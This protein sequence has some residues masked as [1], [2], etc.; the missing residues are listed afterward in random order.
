M[1]SSMDKSLYQAP[2]GLLEDD[3]NAEITD[4]EIILDGEDPEDIED[5][6]DPEFDDNLVDHMDERDVSSLG[7]EL[8]EHFDN[9]CT[10][11]K[12]WAET[13]VKGLKLLGLK[14]EERTEPWGGACGAYHPI[15]AEAVV[16]FQA[17]SIMEQFPASGPVKTKIV[18]K[19]TKEN[20]AAAARVMEDMNFQLTE[21]MVEYRPEHEKLLWSLPLAGSAFKKV[22][23]DPTM[24]RQVALFVPAED[25][26]VPYGASSLETSERVTHVMRKTKNELKKMQA[27]GFYCDVE[28]GEPTNTVDDIEKQKAEEQGFSTTND[29]RFKVL[30]MH[31]DLDLIGFEDDDGIALPYI[32]TI[33]QGT[34]T[35]LS[36]RRNWYE[37]DVLRLKR[38]HFV[39]YTYVP[40][41]GF[42]GLGL[43]HLVGG[44]AQSATSILRQLV[45][46][47]TLSNLPG[48]FKTKG[49]RVKGDDT[50]V[51]PGEFRDV[52]VAS[53][54]LKDNI[55]PLPYK[56]PSQTLYLLMQN[57]VEEGRRFASAGDL[58]ISDMSANT[59]VGTT[60]A[61]LER[62]L[63]T[64]SAVQAR[65]HFAMK[66]EFKL[67]A[68][69]TRD[70]AADSEYGYEVDGGD[71]QAQ[72]KQ[73]DYDMCEV[74]PVSDPNASTMSQKIVQHQ[75]AMQ[76]ANSAPQLYDLAL[77]HRQG[78]EILGMKNVNKLVPMADDQ[79]PKDPVSENMA[80]LTMKPV[81]AFQYQDHEAH[82]A[83]H[84][85]MAQDP[86]IAAMVG[87]N[88]QAQIIIANGAAHL[89]EH[90]AM[91]YKAAIEKQLGVPLPLVDEDNPMSPEIE[92]QVSKLAAQAA[93]QLLQAN[94]AEAAQQ[95]AQQ[96]AQDPVIQMQQQELKI[97]EREVGVKEMAVKIDAA[98]RADK[99][100]LEEARL[101]QE[102]RIAGLEIG[103]KV[104]S[105]REKVD[106]LSEVLLAKIA[107]FKSGHFN[108]GV[109]LAMQ[110]KNKV[111]SENER[112]KQAQADRKVQEILDAERLK[113]ERLR[114]ETERQ[115][116]ENDHIR[117][118]KEAARAERTAKNPPKP[119]KEVKPYIPPPAPPAPAPQPAPPPV[120]N[121]SIP[122]AIDTKKGST[123]RTG[124]A[125][126]IADGTWEMQSTET[127][128]KKEK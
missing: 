58:G 4:I 42:Y 85:S 70:N 68:G 67:L 88:P 116:M 41:T 96:K 25:L 80:L 28:L 18:G 95:Q 123:I 29:D 26:V 9:D 15:L 78:L 86:K 59:P 91:A 12:D 118:E 65:L 121:I 115:K 72:V 21:R 103:T 3:P 10:A 16:K 81:K 77:L 43:I 2:V 105:E 75:A 39:H 82:I 104:A 24:G 126:K 19:E 99:Q 48:G 7:T 111:Q 32:V 110:E 57:I 40:S 20:I 36:I 83:V 45:D 13:Y 109:K 37:D 122:L 51:S 6:C 27:A 69:I 46:A 17:E 14:Y 84:M 30:E 5:A 23:M 120:I 50:P 113:I 102:E 79:V 44:F 97:K 52:D 31:V 107:E 108:E 73:S 56:E 11:R 8:V 49:L 1:K 71:Q 87:Q 90:L 106:H 34:K 62:T 35:V 124:K 63:K 125:V 74:I 33:E 55:M 93:Q 22:Y 61:I 47:G 117:A 89:Q 53:G 92:M 64:M 94:Q 112:L 54:V 127:E 60:L 100:Q 128:A 76:L 114:A 98:A 66:Q 38:Q 119:V 101:A